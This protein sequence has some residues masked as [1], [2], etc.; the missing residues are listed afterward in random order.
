MK[1]FDWGILGV[2]VPLLVVLYISFNTCYWRNSKFIIE[3]DI[4]SYYAYLPAIFIHQDPSLDFVDKLSFSEKEKIWYELTENNEKVIKTTMGVAYMYFPFFMLAQHYSYTSYSYPA[5]GYTLPYR[6]AICM[7]SIF[8][9]LLAL[10]LL[11]KLL[12]KY[13]S[14][15]ITFFVLTSI[16]LGTNLLTYVTREPGMSHCFS[17]FLISL[18]LYFI[19]YWLSSKKKLAFLLVVASL[20]L[21]ILVRPSNGI[22]VLMILGYK[23]NNLKMLK[24]RVELIYK[25]WKTLILATIVFCIILFPQLIYWK[26]SSGNWIF[27]SYAGNE[28]FFFNDPMIIKGLFSYRK[29]WLVYSPIM[30]FAIVGFLLPSKK[31]NGIKLPIF[32]IL[33]AHIYIVYSWWS[34]WFAGSFGSRPL[35]DI[36][37]L[38]SIPLAYFF[39]FFLSKNFFIKALPIA[40]AC[41]LI[42]LSIF[43]NYQ[44]REGLIHYHGMT[45]KTYW[46]VFLKEK[47]PPGYWE[48]LDIPD[49]EA[50]K[51][52][53]RDI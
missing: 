49:Y 52:G 24:E 48:D 47:Y 21:I 6:F 43:Q 1:K 33:L 50:A 46:G 41:L 39:S 4:I 25:D 19:D 51:K 9:F 29:G 53:E 3:S 17:F 14:G 26:Y 20:A 37:P 23:V 15:W 27:D 10:I 44:Y 36:Y 5:N 42:G 45:K 12:S 7:A 40:T 34:W 18:Y 13:F 8:Y 16:T 31:F 22:V 35:I 32:M 30:V 38:L 11:K 2:L 28:H